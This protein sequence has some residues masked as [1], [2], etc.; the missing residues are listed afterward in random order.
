MSV[1][2][3]A[4]VR[5]YLDSKG[6][7]R[8]F[9]PPF[10]YRN[11]YMHFKITMKKIISYF[12]AIVFTIAGLS[13]EAAGQT[14]PV[15]Q[16]VYFHKDTLR[17]V[18]GQEDTLKATAVP[19]AP[20]HWDAPAS[21]PV[22]ATIAPPTS[23]AR[24]GKVYLVKGRKVGKTKVIVQVGAAKDT[25]WVFVSP[26]IPVKEVRL[27]KDTVRLKAGQTQMIQAGITPQN[28]TDKTLNWRTKGRAT[29]TPSATNHTEALI[30]AAAVTDTTLIIAEAK[31]GSKCS[32]T[33]VVITRVP[34]DSIRLNKD[35][36][37]VD[38]GG[39]D[40]L[41]AMVY[42]SQATNRSLN[43]MVKGKATV[44]PSS[45]TD[46]VAFIAA[47]LTPD[48]TYVI[49]EAKDSSYYRD[50]C[51]I[52][53]RE[54]GSDAVVE[55]ND[56]HIYASEGYVHIHSG[57]PVSLGIYTISGALYRREEGVVGDRA[58]PLPRGFYIVVLNH[59]GKKI[60]VR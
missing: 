34:L 55:V 24:Y 7:V 13:F 3:G 30:T 37:R 31:D 22:I 33:C 26:R 4:N 58:I 43:W 36:L 54:P 27:N 60:F 44:T 35:T 9:A 39:K 45:E 14:K 19:D 29:V 1:K 21:I 16:A 50:T 12:L 52:I 20:I 5:F 32:D 42:P 15:Q 28:A 10:H 18:V 48:T 25:C 41:W 11:L 38:I 59:T 53:T 40:T 51:V 46:T 47:A 17:L 23:S 56:Q 8:T 57:K 2:N 49:V 6:K